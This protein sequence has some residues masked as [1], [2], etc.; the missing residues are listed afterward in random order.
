MAASEDG[1]PAALAALFW[2]QA[3]TL[4]SR[5]KQRCTGPVSRCG[6]RTALDINSPYFQF[7]RLRCHHGWVG[8]SHSIGWWV[9]D[10][11]LIEPMPAAHRKS[12]GRG[13]GRTFAVT[14]TNEMRAERLRKAGASDTTLRSRRPFAY[15][16]PDVVTDRPMKNPLN[17]MARYSSRFSR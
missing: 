14:F 17:S 4:P 2:R 15:W 13:G 3:R 9:I 16:A 5:L 7:G 6:D 10:I 11:S 8:S 12:A 1:L